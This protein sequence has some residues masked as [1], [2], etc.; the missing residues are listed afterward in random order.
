MGFEVDVTAFELTDWPEGP[1]KEGGMLPSI[2]QGCLPYC[3]GLHP[4]PT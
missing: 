4:T 2:L 3:L 1:G